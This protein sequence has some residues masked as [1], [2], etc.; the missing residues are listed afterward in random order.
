M[1]LNE[2]P[3]CGKEPYI[4][5]TCSCGEWTDY[6]LVRCDSCGLVFGVGRCFESSQE[7]I[8]AWNDRR[9]C[10]TCREDKMI[11]LRVGSILQ[12]EEGG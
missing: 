1:D 11:A 10:S 3:I 6:Y 4:S 5:R 2:C 8:R 9:P 12:S 7:A